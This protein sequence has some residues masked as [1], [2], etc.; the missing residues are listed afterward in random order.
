MSSV[1]KPGPA[2]YLTQSKSWVLKT[3]LK[4]QHEL[5]PYASYVIVCLWPLWYCVPLLPTTLA[6]FLFSKH[7]VQTPGLMLNPPLCLKPHLLSSLCSRLT[8]STRPALTIQFNWYNLFPSLAQNTQSTLL[9]YAF[10]FAPGMY[11][12]LT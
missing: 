12:L 3:C 10:C 11:Q 1:K 8:P 6:F 9:Y 7:C 4:D 2:L 5:P